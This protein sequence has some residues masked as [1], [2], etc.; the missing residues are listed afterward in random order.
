[1]EIDDGMYRR[2]KARAVLEGRSVTEIVED[3]IRAYLRRTEL[4]PKTGSLRDLVP[5]AYPDGN[6]GLSGDIDQI[7]Y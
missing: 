6:E 5:E 3:A 2:L 4:L 7:V 1:M